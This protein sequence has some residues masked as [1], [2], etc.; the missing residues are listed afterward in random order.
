MHLENYAGSSSVDD[1]LALHHLAVALCI[2][3][4]YRSTVELEDAAIPF[5]SVA[6][7]VAAGVVAAVEAHFVGGAVVVVVGESVLGRVSHVVIGNR[8]VSISRR[9][10]IISRRCA[11]IS[12]RRVVISGRRCRPVDSVHAGSFCQELQHHVGVRVLGV[13]HV[14]Q[15]FADELGFVLNRQVVHVRK[16][17]VDLL[18]HVDVDVDD[19]LVLARD[20]LPC[21]CVRIAS[22]VDASV[23][24]CRLLVGRRNL[25]DFEGKSSFGLD[26]LL[27]S[28]GL[29][30]RHVFDGDY[31]LV[32]H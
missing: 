24:T 19:L 23:F 17:H 20:R 26:G 28:L 12:G 30:L 27:G 11:M 1:A 13:D 4:R 7:A 21:R 15:Q 8:C 25:F 9:L 14:C 16:L 18:L 3:V 5:R 29:G 6:V 31:Y 22:L 10:I 2:A 32:P